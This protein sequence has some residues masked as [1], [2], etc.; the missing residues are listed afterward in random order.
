MPLAAAGLDSALVPPRYRTGYFKHVFAGGYAAGYYSYIWSEVLDAD[1]VE[2]FRAQ[3]GLTRD[4]GEHFRAELLSRGNTRD[5]LESY[6][7]FRGGDADPEHLLRR[8]G[9]LG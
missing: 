7:A 3:G 1:T 4:N 6:R 9:L 2:W 5:P 8:R